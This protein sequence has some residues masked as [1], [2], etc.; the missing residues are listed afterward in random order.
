MIIPDNSGINGGPARAMLLGGKRLELGKK[1]L[2][3]ASFEIKD[4]RGK[5][6]QIAVNCTRKIFGT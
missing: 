3:E 4:D 6:R 5:L 1:Y 2:P